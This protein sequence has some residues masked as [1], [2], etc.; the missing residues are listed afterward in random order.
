MQSITRET[1]AYSLSALLHLGVFGSLLVLHTHPPESYQTNQG[2]ASIQLMASIAAK[3]EEKHEPKMEF[4]SARAR[5]EPSPEP[6]AHFVEMEKRE[7]AVEIGSQPEI[8][9]RPKASPPPKSPLARKD[10]EDAIAIATRTETTL[11]KQTRPHE[12]NVKVAAEQAVA[13]APSEAQFGTEVE[14]LPRAV[15]SNPA[16]YYPADLQQAGRGGVVMLRLRISAEGLVSTIALAASSG[17]AALDESALS[18]VRS[19]RFYPAR[20]L[21]HAV[22]Y[23]V[24]KPIRFTP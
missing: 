6:E 12:P 1:I 7:P 2:R 22:A 15:P 18:T 21:G 5:F 8:D 4:T 24:L 13:S 11:K 19:W 23:D 10:L 9:D 16:P 14:E 17:I 20:R 3:P